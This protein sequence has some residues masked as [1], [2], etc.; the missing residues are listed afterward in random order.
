LILRKKKKKKNKKKKKKKKKGN[1]KI[2]SEPVLCVKIAPVLCAGSGIDP[3]TTLQQGNQTDSVSSTQSKVKLFAFL[4]SKLKI[5]L[6]INRGDEVG[7]VI[8]DGH[9]AITSWFHHDV[10]FAHTS[11]GLRPDDYNLFIFLAYFCTE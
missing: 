4:Q 5:F 11:S 3:F 9:K 8:N 6:W 7:A 1:F 10:G 2:I